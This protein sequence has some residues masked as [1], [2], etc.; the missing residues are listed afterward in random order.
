MPDEPLV[1]EWRHYEDQIFD[2]LKQRAGDAADVQFDQYLPGRFSEVDRQMDITVR[3]MFAPMPHPIL[4]V[5]DCKCWSTKVD[6][7]DVEA[8]IGL[9]EDVGATLRLLIT[10]TGASAAA[11][12]RGGRSVMVEVVPFDDLAAWLD[13]RPAVSITHG[14][15]HGTLSYLVGGEWVTEIVDREAAEGVL[16]R[17]KIR[18]E[19]LAR[20]AI[21]KAPAAPKRRKPRRRS[22][23]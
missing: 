5:A 23:G 11:D 3:G 22:H 9:V 17:M 4:A 21:R 2:R 15:A 14:A 13:R 6:V 7:S 10:K 19:R 8:L 20:R 1:P 16:R 12:R 18:E